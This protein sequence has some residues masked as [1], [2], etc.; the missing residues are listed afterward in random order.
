MTSST[1][2]GVAEASSGTE[3]RVGQAFME[4]DGR[5]N[6]SYIIS[7]FLR[8]EEVEVAKNP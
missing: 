1:L 7:L 2:P 4:G 5:T 8:V 6:Q 3:W